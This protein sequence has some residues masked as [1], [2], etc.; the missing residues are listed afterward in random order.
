MGA[1]QYKNDKALA[2]VL[3]GLLQIS[4][5]PGAC[6]GGIAQTSTNGPHVSGSLRTQRDRVKS[7]EGTGQGVL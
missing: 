3:R 7:L 6:V 2:L 4:N 5:T 1:L